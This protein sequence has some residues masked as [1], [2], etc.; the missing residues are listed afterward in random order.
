MKALSPQTGGVT[1][2]KERTR[3]GR[4]LIPVALSLF[5]FSC[6]TGAVKAQE[7]DETPAS[8]AV[9]VPERLAPKDPYLLRS[10]NQKLVD[11]RGNGYD[12]LYGIRN[13]R[14]VLAGVMYRGGANNKFN[15]YGA[16][17][18]HNPLPDLGL[19]NLCKEGFDTAVYLYSDNFETAPPKVDCVDRRTGKPNSL[20]YVQIGPYNEP[21]IR[22]L[23]SIVHRKIKDRSEGPA[24][25]HCWNGWHASGLI[26]AY[27]LRQFCGVSGTEAVKYWN[28]NTDGYDDEP[29][30]EKIR[31]RIRDFVPYTDLALTAEEKKSLCLPMTAR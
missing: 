3:F 8:A 5:A 2:A 29:A 7:T 24:Y 4:I 25:F 12:D 1:D 16:R 30:F 17:D 6:S 31:K 15:R 26:S 14:A 22:K 11:N 18:N 9:S 27:A 20:E 13:F 19:Q 28:L 21:A 23:L 10:S